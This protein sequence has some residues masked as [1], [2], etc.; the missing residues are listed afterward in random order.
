MRTD[1]QKRA[2]A[3]YR[4]K[5]KD[6]VTTWGTQLKKEE[7]AK[8]DAII[9]AHGMNRAQFLRWAAREIDGNNE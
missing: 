3:A 4:Q 1:A 2:D 7:A 8:I 6:T 5:T 9:K